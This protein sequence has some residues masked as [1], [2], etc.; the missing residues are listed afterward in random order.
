LRIG[1][2]TPN[3]PTALKA[4]VTAAG[5]VL[6]SPSRQN[7]PDGRA[8]HSRRKSIEPLRSYPPAPAVDAD[9][10]FLF[11]LYATT[12]VDVLHTNRK[13]GAE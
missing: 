8:G 7:R 2:A 6:C 4:M 13:D 9:R 10:G 12:R 1:T 5:M 11:A 3:T